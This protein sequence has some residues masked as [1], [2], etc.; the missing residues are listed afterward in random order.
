VA[1]Y[2]VRE[3]QE[4]KGESIDSSQGLLFFGLRL[5]ARARSVRQSE[6]P[7]NYITQIWINH[8]GRQPQ[9]IQADCLCFAILLSE[10]YKKG[11]R[12][13][14]RHGTNRCSGVLLNGGGR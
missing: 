11:R 2:R 7:L 13:G 8:V 9:Q 10:E 4:I 12:T 5:I 3:S 1:N 6:L 14:V